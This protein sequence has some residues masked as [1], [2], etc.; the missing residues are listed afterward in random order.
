MKSRNS[1]ARSFS[2]VLSVKS[3][4]FIFTLITTPLLTRIYS[5]D[6]YGLLAV[7]SS[8][9]LNISVFSTGKYPTAFVLPRHKKQFYQLILISL[10]LLSFISLCTLIA[11]VLSKNILLEWF[12]TEVLGNLI[13]IIPLVI[14]L[15]GLGEI[16][17]NWNI[18]VKNFGKSAV[19]DLSTQV[20][21]KIGAISYGKLISVNLNGL[22]IFFILDALFA[23]IIQGPIILK[24]QI[25][26]PFNNISWKDIIQTGKEY[27]SYPALVLPG[28]YL[29]TLSNQLPIFTF[30]IYFGTEVVGLLGL[31]FSIVTIPFDLLVNSLN[32]IFLQRIAELKNL[33]EFTKIKSLV[34]KGYWSMFCVGLLPFTFLTIFGSTL[35]SL[36]FGIQW[37]LSGHFAGIL[38]LFF[39]IRMGI[40]PITAVYR[41][42]R[43]ERN[44][45]RLNLYIFLLRV[46]GLLPGLVAHS[47]LLT[48][49]GYSIGS[50]LGYLIYP[51]TIFKRLHIKLFNTLGLSIILI[52]ISYSFFFIIDVFLKFLF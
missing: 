3:I 14:F 32:P 11:I 47:P 43:L 31:A 10:C 16:F 50:C 4:G 25:L 30:S 17:F 33:D 20:F 35:F 28:N 21:N 18:R 39:I 13:Y 45:L 7:F 19:Y 8:V 41:V 23:C 22:T 1:F 36:F 9:V 15:K 12:N 26:R 34:L 6:A 44:I 29:N 51:V 24:K 52:L 38:G 46:L 2:V 27:I 48:L 49:W 37:Q 40:S 42:L 5:P